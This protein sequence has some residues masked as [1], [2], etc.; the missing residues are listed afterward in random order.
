MVCCPM[1]V[2]GARGSPR[3]GPRSSSSLIL[4][5]EAMSVSRLL[6]AIAAEAMLHHRRVRPRVWSAKR[7]VQAGPSQAFTYEKSS[8]QTSCASASPIGT[9][10]ASGVFAIGGPPQAGAVFLALGAQQRCGERIL[11]APAGD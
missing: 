10:R 3:R 9:K 6:R 5:L 11:R 1:P 7:S 8:V 4:L 2:N